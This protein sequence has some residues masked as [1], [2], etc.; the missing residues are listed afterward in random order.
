[1]SGKTTLAPPKPTPAKMDR[2]VLHTREAL[3]D[4]LVALMHEMPFDSIT[5]QQVLDRAEV[6]RSTFYSHYRDKDDLFLSDVEDFFELTS[7]LLECHHDKSRRVAPVAELF[8]HVAEARE[9]YAALVAS[10]KI[11][12]VMQ[13]G[14]GYMARSIEQRLSRMSERTGDCACP[15]A[16]SQALAGAMLSLMSWWIGCGMPGTPKEMDDLFHKLVWSGIGGA[17]KPQA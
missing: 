17:S 16:T 10:G 8:A 7:T 1:M 5:V 15:T 6:G 4:A 14:Q 9:F 11:H 12:D 13:L 3:G 2:R